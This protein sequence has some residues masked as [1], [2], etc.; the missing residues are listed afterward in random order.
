M[1]TVRPLARWAGVVLM[2]LLAGVAVDAVRA[3]PSRTITSAM[4]PFSTGATRVIPFSRP[5]E[6]AV[7]I[8]AADCTSNLRMLHLLHRPTVRDAV[9]L[10]VVWFVGPASDS[11]VIRPLLP[12]WARATPLRVAPRAL[13]RELAR[14]GHTSTPTLVVLDQT[15]R[16][17]LASQSPRSSREYAGL[18]RVVEGLTWIEEL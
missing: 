3:A 11:L 2:M 10:S 6:A 15:G 13:L 12:S 16:V 18:R 5:L 1:D 17:R 8:Q 4:L 9:Q 14:L 7:V